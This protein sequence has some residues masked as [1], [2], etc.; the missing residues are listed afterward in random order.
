MTNF[1]VRLEN[2]AGEVLIFERLVET[3]N[4]GRLE[5]SNEVQPGAGPPMHVHYKQEEGLTVVA[6]RL[7]Y[8]IQGQAP[9]YAEPGETVVFPTGV[10]HRFWADAD[11]VL[12]CTGYIEP[13]HNVV[14]FLGEIYRSTRENGGTKPD[15]FESAYLLHKYGSE[16]G[17]LDI[18]APVQQFVFPV[19]RF[20]GGLSGKFTRF[21]NGP[22]PVR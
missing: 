16:F 6:G 13:A 4:G 7:G 5:V 18:P 10:A 2:G 3:A 11:Q 20:I 19:L 9:Q 17:I 14:Y 12:R 21:A 22:E 1:P 15:D 8:Q